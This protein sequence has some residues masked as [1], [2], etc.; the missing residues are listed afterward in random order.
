MEEINIQ[1]FKDLRISYNLGVGTTFNNSFT[2]ELMPV[3]KRTLSQNGLTDHPRLINDL[4]IL[5]FS[6]YQLRHTHSLRIHL[7]FVDNPGGNFIA[8]QI[9]SHHFNEDTVRT[10]SKAS[11]ADLIISDTPQIPLKGKHYFYLDNLNDPKSWEGL[12]SEINQY[13]LS[14]T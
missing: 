3:I 13:L 7:E 1:A 8:R 11:D 5:F 2:T 10:V 4:S 12:F 9:I 14:S 6:F